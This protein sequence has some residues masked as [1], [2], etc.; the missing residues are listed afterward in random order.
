VAGERLLDTHIKRFQNYNV[1]LVNHFG[2][3]ECPAIGVSKKGDPRVLEIINDG[4]FTESLKENDAER[5][6]VTD[7]HNTATPIVRYKT[8]DMLERVRHNSD[9]TLSQMSIVGRGDDLVKIQGILIPKTKIIE[10]V[11]RFT[12]KFL[13]DIQTKKARDFV[14]VTLDRACKKNQKKIEDSLAFFKKW[15][16]SFKKHFSIPTTSSFKNRY[17]IDSR[18]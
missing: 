12:D 8:G 5:F 6:V 4:I 3:T 9:G 10:I 14:E 13:V 1:E 15:K 7:L 17:V 16:I 11:S 2:L 18:R